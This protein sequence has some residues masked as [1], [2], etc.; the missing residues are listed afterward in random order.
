MLS[1]AS[2]VLQLVMLVAIVFV[3][4]LVTAILGILVGIPFFGTG[5]LENLT[6]GVDY[7]DE[8]MIP[9]L[10]YLQIV[11]QIGVFINVRAINDLT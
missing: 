2:P 4:L 8:S 7:S 5:I 10:K 3:S 1:G 6:Q 11:N 9:L